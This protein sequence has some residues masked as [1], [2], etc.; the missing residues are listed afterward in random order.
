MRK[1]TVPR[2]LV[3]GMGGE[4]A[5]RARLTAFRNALADHAATVGEPRPAEVSA[6][7]NLAGAAEADW[8]VE[9]PPSEAPPF[10]APPPPPPAPAG[11]PEDAIAP[12]AFYL[13][14]PPAARAAIRAAAWA[15][16]AG[17]MADF[18]DQ[19]LVTSAYVQLSHTTVVAGI[20]AVRDAGMMTEAEA[21]AVL[22]PVVAPEERP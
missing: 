15:D 6:I 2:A 12:R 3:E 11:P 18:H 5:F 8:A 17:S 10:G 4:A 9:E 21:A 16:P 19:L 22:D 1:F 13:R 14:I 7:E 20:H